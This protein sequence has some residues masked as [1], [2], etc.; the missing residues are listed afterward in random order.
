MS[1]SAL[2]RLVG[3]LVET[4]QQRKLKYFSII[5]TC[6]HVK[7]SVKNHTMVPAMQFYLKCWRVAGDH[8]NNMYH[9]QLRCSYISFWSSRRFLE[10]LKIE[11]SWFLKGSLLLW[12]ACWIWLNG[13][14]AAVKVKQKVSLQSNSFTFH[15]ILAGW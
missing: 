2:R 9:S 12:L 1:V 5:Y 6:T 11:L 4:C 3:L 15:R 7:K 10:I 14:I 13:W 8:F